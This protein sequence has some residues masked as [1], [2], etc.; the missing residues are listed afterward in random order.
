MWVCKSQQQ[1]ILLKYSLNFCFGAGMFWGVGEFLKNKTPLH[2][3]VNVLCNTE[4]V[5]YVL[6]MFIVV[7]LGQVTLKKSFFYSQWVLTWLNKGLEWNGRYDI[8]KIVISNASYY[9]VR[10]LFVMVLQSGV[11]SQH[12]IDGCYTDLFV[13]FYLLRNESSKLSKLT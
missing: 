2:F 1:E 13:Q 8:T 4:I 3:W 7:S 6:C 12:P 11:K 5:A 10:A 9:C